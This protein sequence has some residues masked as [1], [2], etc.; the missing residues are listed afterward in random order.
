MLERERKVA[1]KIKVNVRAGA[2]KGRKAA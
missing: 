1:M 2:T